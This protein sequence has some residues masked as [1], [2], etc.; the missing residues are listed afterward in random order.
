[1]RVR[2][3]TYLL[4]IIL[5]STGV[6]AFG[7][8]YQYMQNKTLE[9][10]P[11]QNYMFKLTVQNKDE[12]DIRVNIA[13]DSAIATLAGGSEL[14]VPGATYDRHVFFNITIP[15]DAQPGD[16]YN[17][18]YLVRPLGRGEGQVPFTVQYDRNF[19][20]KVVPKPKE[21]E[22]EKPAL[23]PEE[24]KIPKWMFIPIIIIVVLVLLILTWKKSHQMSG[25]IIK[26]KPELREF[27]PQHP[28]KKPDLKELKPQLPIVEH[29]PKPEVKIAPE[30]PKHPE[31]IEHK[32]AHPREER[33]LSPHKYFHLKDGKSL[34][35]LE[36]VYHALK[37]MSDNTFDHHVSSAK[38]D[39]ARWIAHSLGKEELAG[40]LL[41][42]ATREE[43]LE[44]I[45]NELE[46][47]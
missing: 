14:K 20:I 7:I 46:K 29:K 33:V 4:L 30:P 25:R 37:Y 41:T 19:K 26:K 31:H 32:P 47:K 2:I 10:Y 35:N 28:L 38:N 27:K 40:R 1:M 3:L 24:T 21:V 23:I 9:L 11:G 17:I 22:E 44:L 39:F 43:M 16:M 5:V 42:K 18:N 6:Q 8:S 45:K 13:L 34:K 15:E 12:E 36:E